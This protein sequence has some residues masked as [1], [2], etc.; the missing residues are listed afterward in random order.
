[1]RLHEKEMELTKLKVEGIGMTTLPI[2]PFASSTTSTASSVLHDPKEVM[3]SHK[4]I[5]M[6][7]S[8][9]SSVP[10]LH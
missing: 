4:E 1:M 5:P 9:T 7:A 10:F 8:I 3:T 6:L 2:V